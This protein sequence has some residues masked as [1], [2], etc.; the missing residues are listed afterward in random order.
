MTENF[1][2]LAALL[3]EVD[4]DCVCTVVVCAG[5]PCT[6]FSDIRGS[7]AP[8]VDGPEGMKFV[9]LVEWLKT[10]KQHIK[11]RR[12]LRLIE[13]VL[14]HRRGDI[15]HF[16]EALDCQAIILDAAGFGLVSRPRVWWSDICWDGPRAAELLGCDP[17]WSRHFW[18]LE[19]TMQAAAFIPSGWEPP[20]CWADGKLM[21][22]L[23]TPAPTD[24]GRDA[25]RSSRGKMSGLVHSRWVGD[26]RQCAPWRYT[27]KYMLKNPDGQLC[28]PPAETKEST[29]EI[30]V[31][32]TEGAP[33]KLRHKWLANSWHVGVAKLLLLMLILQPTTAAAAKVPK[34]VTP[35]Y[36]GLQAAWAVWGG[37]PPEVG[38]GQKMMAPSHALEAE[39]DMWQRWSHAILLPDPRLEA[40]NPEPGLQRALELQC[41]LGTDL[42]A[43][44]GR[45]CHDITQLVTDLQEETEIWW[46]ALPPHVRALYQDTSRCLQIPA[47]EHLANMFH[48]PDSELLTELSLGFPMLGKFTKGVGWPDREDQRYQHPWSK[49]DFI[50]HNRHYIHQ[51]L[52]RHRVDENWHSMMQEIADDVKNGGMTGPHHG[53]QEWPKRMTVAADFADL[54]CLHEGPTEHEP[55]SVAFAIHQIGF[56]GREKMRRGEDWRR[57]GHNQTITTTD[58]PVNHRPNSFL[59]AAHLLRALRKRP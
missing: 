58:G 31:G 50:Q 44:R 33:T 7:A 19:T 29:R 51:K 21:P 54:Q 20:Q 5:P 3:D 9:K 8:G 48:W 36:P 14:P 2:D 41:R 42:P 53:P 45:V 11:S 47:M 49:E 38:P 12:M 23:T 17:T 25:P 52:H 13:N 32:Y 43:L 10:L 34:P 4:P 15:I 39:T 55:T 59:E 28:L 22:C 27:E 6:D 40:L 56:D 37:L 18:D 46:H 35:K 26:N 57:G 30:P 24:A 1:V 16:E